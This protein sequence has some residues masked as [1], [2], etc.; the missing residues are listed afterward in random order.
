M[1][2]LICA[3]IWLFPLLALGQ[4]T[5]VSGTAVDQAA[6]VWSNASI[7]I[8]LQGPNPPYAQGGV[9]VPTTY[10][11]T[12]NG[13]GVFSISLPSNSSLAPG[14]STYAFSICGNTSIPCS[15]PIPIFVTGA[16]QNIS[17]QIT[18]VLG[19]ATVSGTSIVRAYG[20]SELVTP[21][22]FGALFFDTTLSSFKF[23]NGTAWTVIGGGGGVGTI[24]NITANSNAVITTTVLTPTGPTVQFVNTLTVAPANSVLSNST[25]GS[26]APSYT[27]APVVSAANL[28]SFPTGQ[29][30]AP[31]VVSAVTSGLINELHFQEAINPLDFSTANKPPTVVGTVGLTGTLL[32]GMNVCSTGCTPNVA[33][34]GYVLLDPSLNTALTMQI[35]TCANINV[36]QAITGGFFDMP[37]GGLLSATAPSGGTTQA[38]G[39]ML[40]GAQGSLLT[41]DSSAIAKYSV[42][43]SSF[44]NTSLT[45][46]SIEGVG[47]CHLITWTR[48]A[49]TLMD[50]I[51]I[52]GHLSAAYQYI[53]TT[54]TAALTPI[55]SFALGTAPYATLSGT[56]KHPYPIYFFNAYNRILTTSEIQ[57]NYGAIQKFMD[58]RGVPNTVIPNTTYSDPGNQLLAGIDSLTYGFNS[59]SIKGWPF[60]T[61][62]NPLAGTVVTTNYPQANVVNIATVGYQLEQSI[63]ECTTRWQS[64]INPNS[65]TTIIIWGA[66]NDT[67]TQN[68]TSAV[69]LLAVT[70]ATAYQR[71]KRFGQCLHAL[72]PQPRIFVATMI[73]R[74]ISG[75]AG[76]GLGVNAGVPMETLKANFNDSV[77]KD[78]AGFDG[79]IDLASS[80]ALGANGAS[81][82]I[83]GTSCGGARSEPFFAGDSVHLTDCGQQTVSSYMS[84]Y[85]NYADSK[86]NSSNPL[87]VAS[88]YPETS[89]DV[90]VNADT[91]SGS[92]TVTLPTAVALVGTERYVRNIGATNTLTVSA[93]AGELINTLNTMTCAAATKCTFRS[94]L[95][96]SLGSATPDVTAGAHWEIQ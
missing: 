23:W 80:V 77:R 44:N 81:L 27:T 56:Y 93:I 3:F 24:N 78:Y 50:D 36:A 35:Y 75:V 61:T 69:G 12:T 83:T 11:T 38:F 64:A 88:T 73:S 86:F 62:T 79:M 39:L 40:L 29:F 58:Y 57:A 70:P 30:A 21:Q 37:I 19:P 87:T 51:Y 65:A 13:S 9:N 59:F 31:G 74:G 55:T 53:N 4:S 17:A 90:A 71:L 26:A 14:D 72:K 91:T 60:Y 41:T 18:S 32:G 15:N 43:P 42:A 7:A 52:D 2:K 68:A 33:P 82:I 45:T 5:T 89:A 8:T 34:S 67:N 1:K 16:T 28:T 76:N 46:Q 49:S 20:N 47:G 22:N 66:T 6:V 95:G 10:S 25:S 54:G 84:A 92:F 85:L 63:A 94:V 48:K 96:T